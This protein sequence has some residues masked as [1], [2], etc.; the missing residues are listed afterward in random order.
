VPKWAGFLDEVVPPDQ[1]MPVG[2]AT[3]EGFALLDRNAHA[4]DLLYLTEMRMQARSFEREPTN[5]T[6]YYTRS[7]PTQESWLGCSEDF[8]S[9]SRH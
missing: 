7:R 9:N 2:M 3:A 6:R 4:N 8:G 5:S 1:L